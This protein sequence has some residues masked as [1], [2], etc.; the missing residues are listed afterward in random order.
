V[1]FW[2]RSKRD[3]EIAEKLWR[4]LTKEGE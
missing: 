1:F 3:A 2:G 4:E